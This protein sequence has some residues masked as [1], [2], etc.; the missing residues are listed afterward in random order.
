M[1]IIKCSECGKK[2]EP[3]FK[4]GRTQEDW[5]YRECDTCLEYVCESCSDEDEGIVICITCIHQS[6]IDASKEMVSL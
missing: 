6:R 2:L 5:C 1:E 4:A 3:I